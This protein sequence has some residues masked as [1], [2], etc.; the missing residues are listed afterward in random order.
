M[1]TLHGHEG[2]VVRLAFTMNAADRSVLMLVSASTDRTVRVWDA[3]NKLPL[4]VF[5]GHRAPILAAALT[6]SGQVFVTGGDDTN[7]LCWLPHARA[8]GRPPGRVFSPF[9]TC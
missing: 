3:R 1:Q 2:A 7:A 8:R 9:G 5:H 4:R 6:T